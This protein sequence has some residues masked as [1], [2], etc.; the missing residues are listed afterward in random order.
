MK[1]HHAI[2]CLSTI[3]V[4]YGCAGENRSPVTPEPVLPHYWTGDEDY[5]CGTWDAARPEST[6]VLSDVAVTSSVPISEKIEMLRAR[7]A[8]IRHVFNVPMIRVIISVDTLESLYPRDI[9]HALG[10]PDPDCY[11]LEHLIVLYDRVIEEGD[12]TALQQF[13]V[14]ILRESYTHTFFTVNAEDGV[15]PKILQLPGVTSVSLD[16]YLCPAA[17]A[18]R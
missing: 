11:L 8:Y 18:A 3:L 7:G 1:L 12:S 16:Y 13:G 10:V 2:I 5:I 15:I 17:D 14:K 4:V 6:Y 9:L